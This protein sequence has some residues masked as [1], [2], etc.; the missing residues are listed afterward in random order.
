MPNV[1]KMMGNCSACVATMTCS[2]LS[3][4]RVGM[5]AIA[6][7]VAMTTYIWSLLRRPIEGR[8]IHALGK[9]WHPE[10][11]STEPYRSHLFFKERGGASC[12]SSLLHAEVVRPYI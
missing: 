11:S 6:M 10:V 8:I 3:V 2:L 5:C 9:T 12:K 7:H 1:V 4:Q